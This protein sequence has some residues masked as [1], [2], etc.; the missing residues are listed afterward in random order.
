MTVL[1]PQDY[2]QNGDALGQR[3]QIKPQNIKSGTYYGQ[4]QL[5]G[6][7]LVIKDASTTASGYLAFGTS[8]TAIPTS[9]SS[10]TGVYIDYTGV[11][12]LASGTKQFYLQASDGKAYAG[13]GKVI[14][15]ASGITLPNDG[16]AG[17]GFTSSGTYKVAIYANNGVGYQRLDIENNL[18][19]VEDDSAIF[20][21]TIDG[22]S[23]RLSFTLFAEKGVGS[24]A[25]LYDSSSSFLGLLIG[26]TI[27]PS[28]TPT[29]PSSLLHL[30]S[31]V[32]TF[33]ME[34]TTSSAKSLQIKVDGDLAIFE[35]VGG[36]D[37]LKLD[38]AGRNVILHSTAIATNATDGFLYIT[39]CAGTPTGTPTSYTGRVAMVF[40]TTNNKLYV[41]NGGWIDVT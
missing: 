7:L 12:G 16:T 3:K 21:Q 38:L 31:T 26:K 20:L 13:A 1:I 27:L 18:N 23:N 36:N 35:E 41:Y 17:L 11:Y 9:S 24:Y 40:D 2:Q 8:M 10:G 19:G 30:A 14:L 5:R 28:G 29:P 22:S 33:R 15:D 39:S 32:P 37:V 4:L 6:S 34:D 25:G